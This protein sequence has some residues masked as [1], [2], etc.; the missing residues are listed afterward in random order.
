MP[1]LLA[2]YLMIQWLS[3]PDL[4]SLL[5][6]EWWWMGLTF[7]IS[8]TATRAM[9]VIM[10]R[11]HIYIRILILIAP[12]FSRNFQKKLGKFELCHQLGSYHTYLKSIFQPRRDD[13]FYFLYSVLLYSFPCWVKKTKPATFSCKDQTLCIYTYWEREYFLMEIDSLN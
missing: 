8:H 13:I 11:L 7:I 1:V 3:S 6:R 2:S 10:G 9:S 4:R 12:A 5:W